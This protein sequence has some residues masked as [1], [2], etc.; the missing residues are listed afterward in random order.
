MISYE[1]NKNAGVL[2][3]RPKG[4]LETQDFQ[5]LSEVVN[6]FIEESG[7]LNGI[8]IVTERFPGWDDLNG[9]IEHMR[10]VRTHHRKIAKV[11]LVTD[12]KIADVAESFGKHF[13]KASLKHFSFKELESAKR[14]MLK[15][16]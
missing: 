10:F 12:S 15:A 14:W 9:L 16:Q 7:G 2:T 13:V 1:L 5:N 8:I 6:P 11:A 3:V 4:K